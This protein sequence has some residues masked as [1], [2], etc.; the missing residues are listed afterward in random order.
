LGSIE[1]R[2]RRLE[3]S[4]GRCPECAARPLQ[5]YPYCPED[6]ESAPTVPACPSCGRYLGVIL[7]VVYDRPTGEEGEGA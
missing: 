3:E 2:L 5:T 1:A 4:G 7:R 6:G